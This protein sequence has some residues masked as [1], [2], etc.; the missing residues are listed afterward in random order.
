MRALVIS[1]FDDP[2][3]RAEATR[4]GA[5]FLLKP[6]DF[7]RLRQW[8]AVETH[9]NS[10]AIGASIR[11][12]RAEALASR[13]RAGSEPEQVVHFDDERP[14]LQAGVPVRQRIPLVV[15]HHEELASW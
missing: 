15:P 5:L 3:L 4:A 7:V 10:L 6:V 1:G 14:V 11:R 9:A 13:D 12:S 2:D 8:L